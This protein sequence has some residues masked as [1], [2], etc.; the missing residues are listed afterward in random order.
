MKIIT[1]YPLWFVIFCL[2]F[3][4]LVAFLTYSKRF[5]E[6]ISPWQKTVLPLLRFLGASL[7][8]F[9]L[10]NPLILRTITEIEKPLVVV[11]VDN[12][13]SVV[14][15]KDSVFYKTD[16]ITLLREQ[17]KELENQFEV[18]LLSFGSECNNSILSTYN[19]PETDLS[20]LF[21]E[22]KT[23]YSGRNV[24]AIVLASDGI[25]NKGSNPFFMAESMPYPIYSI[26][27]GDTLI[28]KDLKISRVFHNRSVFKGNSFPLEIHLNIDLFPGAKTI[29]KIEHKGKII[30]QK[31]ILA[32][33]NRYKEVVRTYIES[34]LP[35][36][37][38]YS[39]ILEPLEGEFSIQ[40]NRSEVFVEVIEQKEKILILHQAPHPDIAA[41]KNALSSVQSF[42]VEVKN[43]EELNS[44][45]DYQLVILY[46]I[47]SVNNASLPLL[48]RIKQQNIPLLYLLGQKTNLALFN[49][50]NAGLKILQNRVM[51]NDAFAHFNPSF[52]SFSNERNW[53]KNLESLPPLS[54]PFGN[55]QLS[56]AAQIM[57]Y[58]RIGRVVSEMPLML[59]SE[60]NN[61]RTGV[62]TGE[63]IWRWRLM[64]YQI[65]E[66][67]QM[68]DDWM[69]KVVQY[70]M[71][72]SDRSNFRVN[73]NRI[74]N[75]NE[76]VFF[77]AE[78]YN[79][80]MERINEPEVKMM[81]KNSEGKSLPFLFSRTSD[82][83]ELNA[84]KFPKGDYSWE[85]QVSFGGKL[86]AKKGAFTVRKLEIESLNLVADKYLMS[87]LAE[88]NES[89]LLMAREI[90]Q[91][92]EKIK[93]NESIR[94]VTFPV[95]KYTDLTTLWFYFV[96][97]IAL[98]SVE[99]LL[100]KLN[101]MS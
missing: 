84:G 10:L 21:S 56:N 41:L 44:A 99:W 30:F 50:Q 2:A 70:L 69:V 32:Q 78:F 101:G 25:Y 40:N 4:V 95:K 71:V 93:N 14:M 81:I 66:S 37:Q 18:K 5:P 77:S 90:D 64:A 34:D 29:L 96:L 20:A 16:F 53:I 94:S 76:N 47:P 38:Q 43:V 61:T 46:Q 65:Y 88:I 36:L 91:L 80:A 28:Q 60:E 75:E 35:G 51:W 87:Q 97:L 24:G 13:A 98:F 11:A 54:V 17:I 57:L 42:A 39:V 12:S 100:R 62:I 9:L 31:T 79:D 82:A 73:H 45:N 19:E 63:G 89:E 52:V 27:M 72:S 49:E 83:Y 1:E 68:F 55:Y 48:N 23:L 3:G 26:L 74:F 33:G 15:T 67:H 7:L 6:N 59:F 58:Q 8:A 86:F 85:A 22:M 92:S